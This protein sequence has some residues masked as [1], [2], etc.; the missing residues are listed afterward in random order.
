M[1]RS[2]TKDCGVCQTRWASSDCVIIGGRGST[3]DPY[4]AEFN[5]DPVDGN[6]LEQGPNG[7]A[8]FVPPRFFDLPAVHLYSTIEQAVPWD[9]PWP[10]KFNESR[11]NTDQMIDEQDQGI[12]KFNTPGVYLVTLNVRWRKTRNSSYTGDLAAFLMKNGSEYVAL[13]SM[14]VPNG[15]SFAKQSLSTQ[16]NFEAGDFVSGIVKQDVI[17]PSKEGDAGRKI[18]PITVER[19]SP[20]FSAIYLRDEAI[21]AC[22]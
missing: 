16:M 4:V 19:M 12:I 17:D 1:S 22:E 3:D 14:P 15:D 9:A 13:D 20:I 5:I 2:N 7:A 10:L 18:L 11:F 21:E 6:L 8:A